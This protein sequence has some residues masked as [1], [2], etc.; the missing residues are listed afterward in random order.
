MK[1]IYLIAIL[2][3]ASCFSV[4]AQE[5]DEGLGIKFNGFV[6]NDI[7]Y[8]S[9]QTVSAREGHFL[10][11]PTPESMDINGKDINAKSNLNMLAV[12]SRLSG[13]ITGP[14]AFG[15]KTMGKIEGDF[16]A[17]ANDNINLF[18]LRH[19][20]VKLSWDNTHLLFGQ[21]WNPFFVT[22]CFPGTVSFNTGSPIQPFA[23]NPQVRLTQSFGALKIIAAALGQRDYSTR[24]K[25]GPSSDYL[26][27]SGMP[28]MHLQVHLNTSNLTAGAGLA[29]KKIVP[30]LKTDSLIKTNEEVSGLSLIAFSKLTLDPLTIKIEAMSGQNTADVLNISGFAVKTIEPATDER[31]YAPLRNLSV[32]TDIHTNGDKFQVGVFAGYAENN[33]TEE[34]IDNQQIIYGLGTNIA[35]LYRISPRIVFNSGKV[36]FGI[37]GEYTSATFGADYDENA[38]PTDT[39]TTSNMRVIFSTYYFF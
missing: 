16:F 34:T 2:I 5:K 6:K 25:F 27:N 37:E 3:I 32:W 39:H 8:D 30:R 12:Q 17:Q 33:G 14:D 21:Y 4:S 13:T 20:F 31:T 23:R 26:R 15:A 18:R 9:R 35:S 22:D 24:G 29:Y 7:F 10:L 19:A 36:R 38:V 28:D 11:W 1:K